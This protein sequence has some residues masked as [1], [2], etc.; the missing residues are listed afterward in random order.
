MAESQA[1][2]IDIHHHFFLPEYLAAIGADGASGPKSATGSLDA[3]LRGDGQER[4]RDRRCCRCRRRASIVGN[5][6]ET[7]TLARA[8][9]EHAAKLRAAHPGAVRAFRLGADARCRRCARRD[10]L[11]V[12]HAEGRRRAVH[13]ELCDNRWPGDPDF[14]PV[15]DELNRRKA[16]VFIHPLLPDCCAGALNWIP[17]A[18]MEFTHDTNRCVLSLL[19]TGTLDALPRYPLHLLPCRRRGADPR[20]ALRRHRRRA[21][22]SPRSMPNGIDH[23]LKKL[24]Y[25]VALAAN[26]PALAALF[27]Y[28]PVSQV[29]LGSDYPFGTSTDGIR[30]LE[31]FGAQAR[32]S[33]RDLSRQ[34]PAP[35]PAPQGVRRSFSTSQGNLTWETPS[36]WNIAMRC[37]WDA[38]K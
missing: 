37:A 10:R 3:Q 1:G 6:E 28:V 7:K 18:M 29:L 27:T 19:F 38:G 5:R 21:A 14:A 26:K 15:F 13:D 20:R 17:P 22:C 23:E 11:R 31:E 30:G 25:D 35:H 16:V 32:R 2:R 12:R 9:N 36:F 33:R 8:V 24:H 34:R 4:R